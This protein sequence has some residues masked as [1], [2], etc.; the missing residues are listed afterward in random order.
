MSGKTVTHL[1]NKRKGCAGFYGLDK[2]KKSNYNKDND[3]FSIWKRH[4]KSA[5]KAKRLD[6]RHDGKEAGRDVF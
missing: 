5:G 4:G 3:L 6:G 1:Q 2:Y